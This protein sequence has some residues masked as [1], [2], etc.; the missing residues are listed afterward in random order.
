M[1]IVLTACLVFFSFQS[2]CA[3]VREKEP[4]FQRVEIEAN[5]PGGIRGW[6]EFV[7]THLKYPAKAIQKKIEGRVILRFIV[8]KDSTLADFKVMS[9]NSILAEAALAMIK[10]SPK[11]V[12]ANQSGRLVN[13]YKLQPVDFKL[14]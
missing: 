14:K 3:Q 13:S 2:I 10:Q 6:R 4:V 5:F 11:W 7:A 9:G 12:P 8:Y 1:K